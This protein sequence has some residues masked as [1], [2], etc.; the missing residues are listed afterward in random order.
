MLQIHTYIM[1]SSM[2]VAVITNYLLC[3]CFLPVVA[4]DD[5]NYC[6]MVRFY[7]ERIKPHIVV[8]RYV[9]NV[10]NI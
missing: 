9:A 2:L 8:P 1:I 3:K 7:I 4:S 10:T 5:K 6:E